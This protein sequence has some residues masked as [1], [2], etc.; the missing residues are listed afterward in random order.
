M[1]NQDD[2]LHRL[3]QQWQEIEPSAQFEARV[4]RQIR[5]SA[6]SRVPSFA[7][8]LRGWLPRPM[9]ALAAAAV[10]GV[11]IGVSSAVVSV[12]VAPATE[13]LGFLAPHTLAGAL[14]R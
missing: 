11:V 2:Q 1:N 10:A 13:Q 7:D 5:E 12:P 3:L 6:P 9:F 4:W 8:W 14:G